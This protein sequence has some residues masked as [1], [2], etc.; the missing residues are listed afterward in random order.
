MNIFDL[1]KGPEQVV[2]LAQDEDGARELLVLDASLSENHNSTC[3]VTRNPIEDG[4]NISDHVII[5]PISLSIE[6]I[7]SDSPLS[8]KA[9]I[10]GVVAGIPSA[11]F[12]G[13][14][15]AAGTALTAFM[16][17]K[18]IAESAKPSITAYQALSNVQRDKV[19]ISVTTGLRQYKDMILENLT[20]PRTAQNSKSFRFSGTLTNVVIVTS[21]IG[22]IPKSALKEGVKNRAQEKSKLGGKGA[23]DASDKVEKSG[24]SWLARLVS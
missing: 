19:L 11:I 12:G 8:I 13:V 6:G 16:G 15:G 2:F 9:A 20:V 23:K 10:V 4:S 17:N 5:D 24:K 18:L 21:K 14:A 7:I 1:F 3:K 22:F